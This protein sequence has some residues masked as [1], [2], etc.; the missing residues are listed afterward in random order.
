MGMIS[1][2]YTHEMGPNE[3][4]KMIE[5]QKRKKTPP[6]ESPLFLPSVF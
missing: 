3:T 6:I 5:T 4:E 1:D 2:M